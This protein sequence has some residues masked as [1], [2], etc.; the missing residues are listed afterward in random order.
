MSRD[1]L[2]GVRP[3]DFIEAPTS[4][5]PPTATSPVVI[6]LPP[7]RLGKAVVALILIGAC[8]ALGVVGGTFYATK[9]LPPQDG[10]D[11]TAARQLP[12]HSPDGAPLTPPA[13]DMT[14]IPP[15]VTP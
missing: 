9:P 10:A 7:R 4:Y 5:A 15:K 12:R 14:T 6:G 8:I 2:E 11:T 3:S 1:P 13:N